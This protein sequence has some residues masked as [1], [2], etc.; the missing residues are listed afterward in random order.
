MSR[1]CVPVLFVLILSVSALQ[2]EEP[3]RT[4]RYGDPLPEGALARLGT[5]RL[6]HGAGVGAVAFAPDGRTLASG[7]NDGT[8]RLWDVATGKEVRRFG[9]E[10]GRVLRLWFTPDGRVL[11]AAHELAAPSSGVT[12]WEAGTGRQLWSWEGIQHFVGVELS[13]DGKALGVAGRNGKQGFTRWLEPATGKELPRTDTLNGAFL[14]Q[15]EV[16]SPD[17]RTIAVRQSDDVVLR[18]RATGRERARLSRHGTFVTAVAFSPDGKLLASAPGLGCR[19]RQTAARL[20]R[21]AGRHGGSPVAASG[22]R[23]H[24]A[25]LLNVFANRERC[26]P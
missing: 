3:R 17:G 15:S 23:A 2:A 13:A 4:D 16:V 10:P 22:Y 19:R 9:P 14:R 26:P 5:V 25:A 6:R 8:V 18:D 20:R 24:P 21:R 1:R 11:I 7:G 12:A